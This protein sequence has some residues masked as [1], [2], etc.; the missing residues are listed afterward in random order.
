MA[1]EQWVHGR[2]LTQ[3]Q[4]GGESGHL[5]RSARMSGMTEGGGRPREH[6]CARALWHVCRHTFFKRVP[7]KTYKEAL[8]ELLAEP[9]P[10]YVLFVS[11]TVDGSTSG[12]PW[13]GDCFVASPLVK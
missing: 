6:S 2:G 10:H 3:G 7:Y 5:R 9:A 13:C 8:P 4:A 11:G 1:P 12:M